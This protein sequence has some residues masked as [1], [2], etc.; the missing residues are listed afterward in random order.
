[1]RW[2][3]RLLTPL[4]PSPS[5]LPLCLH[6][7][8]VQTN[9]PTPGRRF[10]SSRPGCLNYPIFRTR[11]SGASIQSRHSCRRFSCHA[12]TQV[13]A[14]RFVISP[15]ATPDPHSRCSGTEL[16]A[17]DCTASLPMSPG[18]P[19]SRSPIP[20]PDDVL[21]TDMQSCSTCSI[22]PPSRTNHP[23]FRDTLF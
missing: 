2:Q 14:C 12:F 17:D 21:P 1:M 3:E 4:L 8:P 23:S 5:F 9:G 16:N 19:T 6:P 18:T 15:S 11:L 22:L 7:I 20:R 10:I 13:I